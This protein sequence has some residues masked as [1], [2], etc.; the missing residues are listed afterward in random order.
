LWAIFEP[1]SNTTRRNV[2]QAELA[3]SFEDADE[4]VIAQIARLEQLPP[5]QRLDPDKLLTDLKLAG[6]KA[7][8]LPD[9]ETIVKHVGQ[10]AQGGDVL[11][12]FSNGGFGGIHDKL[13]NFL[14]RK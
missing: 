10:H 5:E 12:V 2:F 6:K 3:D 7:A 14:G 8:Y 13:L 4:V 11:V 9:A 1:R